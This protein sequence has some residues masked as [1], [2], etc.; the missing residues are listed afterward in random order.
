MYARIARFEGGGPE[1]AE[2]A[3]RLAKERFV[4]ELRKL[5]GFAGYAMLG[6][7]DNRTGLGIVLFE[8]EEALEA[9]DR[10]LDA[11]SP[12]DELKDSRR[13]SV[14]RYEVAVHEV[15]GEPTA[16]RASW[17]EG[18]A[19]KMDEGIRKG[20]DDVLP[21]ARQL[22]GWAGV[23]YLVNRSTGKTAVFTLWDTVEARQ[24]SEEAASQ[25][26][27]DAADAGGETITGVERYQVL[28]LEVAARAA[29]R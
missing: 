26:R 18:P 24:A 21:R 14:E 23:F 11:M 4:P 13:T 10:E 3:G 2:I 29:T 6:D 17:L 12:P 15:V 25:L 28:A 8:T 27:Q 16:A 1:T 5:D 7:P 22:D 9:G 20:Q 19:D